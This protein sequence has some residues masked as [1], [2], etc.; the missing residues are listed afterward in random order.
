LAYQL[1]DDF[2]EIVFDDIPVSG[3]TTAKLGVAKLGSMVLGTD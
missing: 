1:D 3:A 2:Y